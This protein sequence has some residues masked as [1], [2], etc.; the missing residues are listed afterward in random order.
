M[1]D[2]SNFGEVRAGLDSRVA[3][4]LARTFDQIAKTAMRTSAEF[5]DANDQGNVLE[6]IKKAHSAVTLIMD[7]AMR[8]LNSAMELAIA[9]AVVIGVQTRD[10]DEGQSSPR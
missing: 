8:G 9:Y 2:D 7:D 10:D 3:A 4:E 1:S 5:S 6:R